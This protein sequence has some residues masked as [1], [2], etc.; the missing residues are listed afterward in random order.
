MRQRRLWFQTFFILINMIGYATEVPPLWYAEPAKE[1][2]DALPLGNGRLA[3]MVFGRIGEERIQFNEESLWSGAPQDA[4]NPNALVVLPQ[5]RQLLF[6]GNYREAERLTRENLL[7]RGGGSLYG[8]SANGAFGAYQTFGDLFITF[9]DQ[10]RVENYRRELDLNTAT[11]RVTYSIGDAHYTRECFISA[12]DQVCVISLSCDQPG[13]ISFTAKLARPERATISA[14]GD[15]ALVMRGQL[16]P[17]EGVRFFAKLRGIAENGHSA[18]SGDALVVE[19]ADSA[20]LLLAATTDFK[21]KPHEQ[22][23]EQQIASAA[24]RSLAQLRE[25]H[26]LDYQSHFQRV[27][28]YLEGPDF[29]EIPT[30]LRLQAM[31][32]GRLDPKLLAQYFQFGR[33]LLISSSRPGCLPAN[34]QGKWAHLIQPPWNCDYHTNINLQ[35][36]YWAAEVANLA[37]CHKPLF[38]FIST[39]RSP[40]SRTAKIH[41]GAR[42]W[43]VHHI[44][45]VWGF[46]SPAEDASWGLF[47]AGGGWLCQHL[48]E[49]YAF[50]LDSAYLK[51]VYP[52][53]K[54]SAQFYLDF[55]VR[56][57]R[58]GYLVTAPSSSPE[59]RF[60]LPNRQA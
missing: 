21:G 22:I 51:E 57:S 6:R 49:H 50:G 28:L 29:T 42:G 27:E 40:G 9:P 8:T 44:T 60:F 11:V 52:I 20:V 25:A 41:Y 36:N 46:T 34:L 35:M 18:A 38:E 4:D 10:N 7:C 59:N 43:V 1:W 47:P 33:Y 30:N 45:N 5:I 12:P 39:L 17:G 19:N 16:P 23:A 48:W 58:F 2:E 14:E 53:L 56:E 24:N 32:E 15:S 13:K 31:K 37:D 54:E 3:A 26:T 55:L